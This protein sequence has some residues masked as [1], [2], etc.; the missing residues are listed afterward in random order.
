M[1]NYKKSILKSSP[2]APEPIV[3]TPKEEPK[4]IIGE[5]AN[6][7]SY[8]NVRSTPEI[9]VGN[10]VAILGKGTR[11]IVTDKKPTVNKDGEWYKIKVVNQDTEGYSMK[12]YI[13]IL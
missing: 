6:V 12:K 5:V 7:D 10:I 4:E 1:K 9:K 13:K 11:I 2:P 3:E 8:L